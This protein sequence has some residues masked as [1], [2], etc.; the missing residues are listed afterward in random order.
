MGAIETS[1]AY[2]LGRLSMQIAMAVREVE[3]PSHVRQDLRRTLEEY[4]RSPC[5]TQTLEDML[6]EEMRR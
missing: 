4:L 1:D 5:R 3:K 6:R 2:W